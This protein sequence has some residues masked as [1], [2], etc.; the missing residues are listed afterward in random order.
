MGVLLDSVLQTNKD[1]LI[2]MLEQKGIKISQTGKKINECEMD[3]LQYEWVL[4]WFGEVEDNG[5]F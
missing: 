1:M 5:W 2:Q 4:S 3:E